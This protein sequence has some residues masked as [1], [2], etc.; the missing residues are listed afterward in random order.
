MRP[1]PYKP[2]AVALCSA[3]FTTACSVLNQASPAGHNSDRHEAE[4]AA[5]TFFTKHYQFYHTDPDLIRSLLTERVFKLLK[6]Q[7]STYTAKK[8]IGSLDCDPWIYAQDGEVSGPFHFT[9]LKCTKYDAVIRFDYVFKI[10]SKS[11]R[12]QS[13]ILK[14]QREAPGSTWRLSD[15]VMPNNESLVEHFERY[16]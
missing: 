8:E 7:Y 10:D 11:S 9:T 6:F 13:V 4:T 15:F 12:P 2:T 3:L 16:P 5:N 1:F 14:F